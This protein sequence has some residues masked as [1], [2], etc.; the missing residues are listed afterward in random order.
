[1]LCLIFFN[2][3]NA[4]ISGFKVDYLELPSKCFYIGYRK[5]SDTARMYFL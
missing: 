1:M 3:L 4:A 2:R 5:M